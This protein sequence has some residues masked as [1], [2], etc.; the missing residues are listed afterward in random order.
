MEQA[1]ERNPANLH[2]VSS[3]PQTLTDEEKD[4]RER[5]RIAEAFGYKCTNCFDVGQYDAGGGIWEICFCRTERKRRRRFEKAVGLRP[6]NWNWM[7]D[8]FNSVAGSARTIEKLETLEAVSGGKIFARGREIVERLRSNQDKS[9]YLHG[10]TGTLKTT[11]GLALVQEAGRRGKE[12]A[13]DIGR[14]L[15]D[16]VRDFQFG[17]KTAPGAGFYSLAQM[18]NAG[19]PLC[20][21]VDEIED[22]ASGLTSYTLSTL[23]RLVEKAQAYN[24]QLIFTSNRS[25]ESLLKHWIRRD[26]KFLRGEADAEN[27]CAKIDRRLQEICLTIELRE[28]EN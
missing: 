16:A 18:E 8:G 3:V 17:Q 14:E 5:Q 25:L 19:S 15:I 9:F 23:F 13:Y 22:T 6:Q 20:L 2:A 28:T 21:M 27:Y 7:T 12:T 26:K 10:E 4:R 11:L 1:S 24:Q